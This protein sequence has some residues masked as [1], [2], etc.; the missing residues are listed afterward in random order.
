[1]KPLAA[2]DIPDDVNEHSSITHRQGRELTGLSVSG[3]R[4]ILLQLEKSGHVI[5]VGDKKNRRYQ[6]TETAP[7]PELP[8][9]T[10][11]PECE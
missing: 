5:A 1:M 4:A 3:V 6:S 7:Q 11:N 10:A 9:L 2:Q 8:P